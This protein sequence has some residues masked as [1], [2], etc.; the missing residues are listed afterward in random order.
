[1]EVEL[2]KRDHLNILTNKA[3]DKSELEID[4]DFFSL[5]CFSY[6]K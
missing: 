5:V 1:M 4:M 3:T 6:L 2:K